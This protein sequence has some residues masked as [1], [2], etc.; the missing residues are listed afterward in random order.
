MYLETP[1]E[2]PPTY[3]LGIKALTINTH[4]AL[5]FSLGI[6]SPDPSV[7]AWNVKAVK[8]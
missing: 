6:R 4:H 3:V 5:G 2:G 1:P 7:P 8:V